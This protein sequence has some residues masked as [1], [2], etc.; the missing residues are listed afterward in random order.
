MVN[1]DMTKDVCR[2][3]QLPKRKLSFNNC[4]NIVMGCAVFAVI[5]ESWGYGK[6]IGPVLFSICVAVC[7]YDFIK[8]FSEI[9]H[10][11]GLMRAVILG[12]MYLGSWFFVA[13]MLVSAVIFSIGS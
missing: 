4:V 10:E 2:S 5:A 6:F 13:V 12:I 7:S 11:A 1:V 9:K 3:Y 8:D